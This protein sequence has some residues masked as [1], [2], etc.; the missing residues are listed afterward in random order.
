MLQLIF[1]KDAKVIQWEKHKLSKTLVR[2]TGCPCEKKKKMN[3]DHDDFIYPK[4]N[5]KWMINLDVKL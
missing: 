2:T 1:N 5:L 4:R 3:F